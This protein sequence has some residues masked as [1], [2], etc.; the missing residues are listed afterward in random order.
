MSLI[1]ASCSIRKF[2]PE[3]KMIL[4]NNY[5][6]IES[7]EVAFTKAEISPYITQAS[8]PKFLGIMPLTWVY[9]K[10]ENKPNKKIINWINETV[11]KKP[12]YYNK[13]QKDNSI[14]QIE[15]YLNDIGYFNSSV[16]TEVY[17]NKGIGHVTYIIKPSNPYIVDEISYS[18][19][20][21]VLMQYIKDVE[22]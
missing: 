14:I 22:S 19:S 12:V 9:Y 16:T 3:D 15:K 20:D 7:D 17:D 6:D 2:V 5:V 4:K 10:T 18:I 21:T 8:N 13:E 11:G 1:L